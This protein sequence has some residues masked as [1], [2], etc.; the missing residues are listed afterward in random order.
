MEFG[1][2]FVVG[3]VECVI[4]CGADDRAAEETGESLAVSLQKLQNIIS[5]NNTLKFKTLIIASLR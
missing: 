3:V 5:K 4:V 2:W 1:V